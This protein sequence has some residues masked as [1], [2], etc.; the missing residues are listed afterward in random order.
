[1]KLFLSIA[2]ALI[3]VLGLI[4]S[5][6]Y[7]IDTAIVQG[8]FYTP[9]LKNQLTAGGISVT[10]ISSYNAAQLSPFD[11]VIHYGN[12]SLDEA[13][14]VSYA[15]GGGTLILTPWF[16]I[17]NNPSQPALQIFNTLNNAVFS[18]PF[19]GATA[20]APGDPLLTGVTFP[21][22]GSILAGWEDGDTFGA[23]VVQVAQY[24][25]G[26]AFIA[27]MNVGA[28][29]VIGINMHVITS[30]TAYN[31]INQPWATQLFINAVGGSQPV[32]E[33]A[34]M[35]LLGSGLLGLCIFRKKF[36]K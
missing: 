10:E 21:A 4:S 29:R 15:T 12:S 31:I 27:Y 19:P 35:L 3:I 28:G 11:S 14:L 25:D 18:A 16:W 32:P 23:G 33:P 9:D 36:K 24:L 22:A 13:A 34:T 17:N 5:N 2:P 30:D 20:I 6:V 8:S 1:M 26:D 7:A